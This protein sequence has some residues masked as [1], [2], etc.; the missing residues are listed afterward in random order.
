MKDLL[1]ALAG[2]ALARFA[3]AIYAR[4]GLTEDRPPCYRRS[5]AEQTF[6]PPYVDGPLFRSDRHA[7]LLIAGFG[8]LVLGP[9]PSANVP[10]PIREAAETRK[11]AA[12][13]MSGTSSL[14]SPGFKATGASDPVSGRLD[15]LDGIGVYLNVGTGVVTTRASN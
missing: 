3:D 6:K 12:A 9:K 5:H 15:Q 10:L 14:L 13:A 1:S 7:P 4:S 2:A 8:F 11:P